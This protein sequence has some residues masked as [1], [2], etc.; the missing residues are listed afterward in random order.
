MNVN[1]ACSWVEGLNRRQ[2]QGPLLAYTDRAM[3]TGAKAH[4]IMAPSF[5]DFE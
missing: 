3:K 4:S 2:P 1:L 5:V